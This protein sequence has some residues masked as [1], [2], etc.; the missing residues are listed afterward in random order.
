MGFGFVG[1]WF[2]RS[3]KIREEVRPTE[4]GFETVT[5]E[6]AHIRWGDVF[7]ITAFKRDEITSDL[8]CLAF[9]AHSLPSGTHV[10]VNEEV[11]GFDAVVALMMKHLPIDPKWRHSVLLP[12]FA[13]N[14]TVIYQT[15]D[16]PNAA[17]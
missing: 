10:E 13:A 15:P 16:A 6:P 3:R 8:L 12:P 9:E 11:P 2:R 7:R 14:Q 4:D 5:T 1:R 17:G